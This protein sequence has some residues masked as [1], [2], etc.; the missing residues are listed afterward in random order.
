MRG[1]EPEMCA[2]NLPVKPVHESE[3]SPSSLHVNE[4]NP[5]QGGFCPS[6]T[7]PQIIIQEIGPK[8]R[9]KLPNDGV[10]SNVSFESPD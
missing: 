2:L 5:L 10:Y 8:T 4:T 9:G 7:L 3:C 1:V 6:T